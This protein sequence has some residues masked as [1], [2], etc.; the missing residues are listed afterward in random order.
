MKFLLL[1]LTFVTAVDPSA[2]ARPRLRE[3]SFHSSALG[4]TMKYRVLV[5]QG[6]E[7]SE[8]RYPV[9]DLLD[10]LMKSWRTE[11]EPSARL[12]RNAALESDPRGSRARRGP[13]LLTGRRRRESP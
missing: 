3:E 2:Q 4:R 1:L 10:V 12:I 7:A 9:L 8:R 11:A 5:P 6:Y 13:R